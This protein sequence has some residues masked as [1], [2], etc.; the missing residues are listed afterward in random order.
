[1]LRH[2]GSAAYLIVAAILFALV[3]VVAEHAWLYRDFRRQWQEARRQ[4]SRK[5]ACSA[6]ESPPS[7]REY[8]AHEWNP[9]LWLTDAA[10]IVVAATLTAA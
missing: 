10:L 2:R 8:F 7:P 5:S 4:V 9:K 3:T 1:M 6:P